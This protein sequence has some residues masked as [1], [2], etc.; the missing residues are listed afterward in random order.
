MG[1]TGYGDSAYAAPRD[2]FVFATTGHSYNVLARRAARTLRE[3]MPDAQIDWFTD[4]TE[5]DTVFD[6]IHPLDA[7]HSRPK[8]EAIRR[9]RFARTVYLDADVIVLA[10]IGEL[11]DLLDRWEFAACHGFSRLKAA[12]HA[13]DGVPRCF[14]N[15][16]SGVIA[17]RN[18]ERV[19]DLM[20]VWARDW[21][22]SSARYD[23]PIL[24]RLLYRSEIEMMIL[25]ME[26]NLIV[27]ALLDG[28]G[29]ALGAPRI[30]HARQLQKQPPGDPSTPLTLR[31]ALPEDRAAHVERLILSDWALGG[32]VSR[33][34]DGTPRKG[35]GAGA[36][37]PRKRRQARRLGAV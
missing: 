20:T 26:Y 1:G 10:D 34:S 23:Q 30:L 32:Q 12:T 28:W 33:D 35:R 15:I 13:D 36:K 18:T 8:M 5:P 7:V 16:N 37:G 6:G 2:G 24:R 27:P 29:A 14:P 4:S 17:C 19:A 3:A 11:F 21:Q 9:S 25:P 22:Q 31:E